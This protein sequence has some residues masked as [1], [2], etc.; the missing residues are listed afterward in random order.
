MDFLQLAQALLVSLVAGVALGLGTYQFLKTGILR[1]AQNDAEALVQESRDQDELKL[2][3][4]KER[5]SE[6]EE[7]LWAP[8]ESQ[9]T[10]REQNLTEDFE[11]CEDRKSR[12]DQQWGQ[13]KQKLLENKR[14]L[15][16]SLQAVENERHKL[17]ELRDRISKL[18]AQLVAELARFSGL[19]LEEEKSKWI[20][21]QMDLARAQG[22]KLID[23]ID[24]SFREHSDAEAKHLLDTVISRFH[25]A[26]CAE[27][28]IPP[29]VFDNL[30]QRKNFTPEVIQSLSEITGCEIYVESGLDY[31]GVAG[32]DPLRREF[33]RRLLERCKRE[34]KPIDPSWVRKVGESL[35]KDLFNMVKKDGDILAK[36]LKL[37]GLHPEIKQMMGSLRY[38]Y[39]FT[40]NQY[41]HCAEVGWLCG[42]LAS[43]L[44]SVSASV[45][46]RSGLLHDLG[47]SMDHEF[48]GGHAVIGAD[49]IEKRGEKPEVVYAVRAHHF[50]VQ[51]KHDLDF[52]VIA[53]DAVSG[54]RPGARRS[55]MESYNQKVSDLDAI[56]RSFDGV[57]DC[58]VLNGGRECRVLVNG[59]KIDDVQALKIGQGIAQRIENEMQY[60]GQIK[61]VVVRETVAVESTRAHQRA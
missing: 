30:D 11:K 2:L 61:V 33:T 8:V 42:L 10:E 6:I 12:M 5:T 13:E 54:A 17:L 23:Q 48:E 58:F 26:Y 41:F 15:D 3:D 24:E 59:R 56:A 50:D 20:D 32:F 7:K 27:R 31:I 16:E 22:Q 60:P 55:T 1:Q 35:Q 18:R 19:S 25:R 9:L 21:Q 29:V 49:F 37:E 44:R 38:R 52:L 45:A 46:R 28:G 57:S 51:P 43:E 47:K 39:S 36:E 4:E 14:S 34:K 53:A 40:Q